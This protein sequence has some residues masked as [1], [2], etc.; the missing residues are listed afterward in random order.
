MKP[1]F[2][3]KNDLDKRSDIRDVIQWPIRSCFIIKRP[4]IM[5]TEKSQACL[6]AFN[7]VCI[8]ISTRDLVQEHI[9]SR[10]GH[11]C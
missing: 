11:G 5:N 8:Y 2:Y 6:I 9:A 3:V 1:W 10:Y 7:D 4:V